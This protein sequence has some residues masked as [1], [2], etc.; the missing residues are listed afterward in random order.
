MSEASNSGPVTAFAP[1]TVANVGVGFDMLG[2]ALAA[3]GDRVTVSRDDGAD[4]VTIDSVQGVVT[5]LPLDPDRNTAS[6][7]VRAMWRDLGLTGGLRILI[8]KGIPLGSGMGGSAA[9]AVAAVVAANA[10]LPEPLPR[11]RLLGYAVLGEEA[12]SGVPHADNAAPC[13]LGGLVA[14]VGN[15]PLKVVP[16]PVPTGLICVLVHPHLQIETRAARAVL[17]REIGLA[18]HVR[19]SMRLTGFLAGCFRDDLELIREAMHDEIVEPQRA[20][21]IPGF[22][23]AKAAALAAGAIGFAIAGSGPS[24]FAWVGS[25]ADAAEVERAIRD[26]F[27]LH[28]LESDGWISPIDRTGAVPLETGP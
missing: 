26:A 10:L 15:D 14:V 16:V 1:A 6:V 7:A 13:L 2:F 22:A 11:Q 12:A 4:G 23:D 5:E 28:D 27:R 21:L 8:E 17:R 24:V 25:R 3:V 20:T 19:H 18:E 9:S